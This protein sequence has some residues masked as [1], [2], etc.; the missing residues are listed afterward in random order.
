MKKQFSRYKRRYKIPIAAV[1][2]RMNGGTTCSSDR[3][4][5]DDE[6]P[7]RVNGVFLVLQRLC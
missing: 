4:K 2:Q 6:V 1:N 5:E 3:D 7:V